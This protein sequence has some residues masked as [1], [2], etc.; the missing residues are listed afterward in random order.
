MLG[1]GNIAPGNYISKDIVW[2]FMKEKGK[3]FVR[4]TG[5]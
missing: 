5:K 1:R 2:N 3:G 4:M